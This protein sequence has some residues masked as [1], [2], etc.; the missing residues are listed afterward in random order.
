MDELLA[1]IK[2]ANALLE[3]NG[4]S[5]SKASLIGGSQPPYDELPDTG[6]EWTREGKKD[7]IEKAL[8]ASLGS[9]YKPGALLAS[10]MD[11]GER[12]AEA[13][14]KGKAGL[15]A[16]G[17]RYAESPGLGM[18]GKATLGT[19]GATGGYVLANNLVDRVIKPKVMEAYWPSLITVVGGVAV[20]GVDVPYRTTSAQR[21][22]F[23][24]WGT[25]KTQVNE[26]YG[27][28]SAVLGTM[29]IIYDIGKQYARFSA[30]SAEQDVM[31]EIVKGFALGENYEIL[32]GP[33]TGSVG[34]GDPVCGIY[35]SLIASSP[36]FTTAFAGASVS[37]IA[38]AAATGLTQ[39]F[40][41]MGKRSRM[42]TAVVTDATTFWKIISEGTDT[43]GYWVSP[44]GGPSVFSRTASGQLQFWGVPL[45]WDANFDANTGTTKAAI[46]LDGSAFKMYRGAEF[47]IDTT[48][49]AGTRWDFNLLG[50]RGEA[51]LGFHAGAGV[52]VGGAQLITGLIP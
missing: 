8:K 28:Y 43:A 19:T 10:L 7:P 22:T 37:T 2:R 31:D 48:D 18:T 23:I 27:T 17:L 38:G 5:P 12:D 13:Q 33:G 45:Y 52:A 42:P 15:Q 6:A 47:R 25:Q 1:E 32:A 9:A 41:A 36:T 29:A 26:A 40:S 44:S 4:R 51:E 39:A 21:A 20:R 49:V 35:T 11:A 50:F 24:D 16:L 3:R 30:G 46:A 34:T 14:F